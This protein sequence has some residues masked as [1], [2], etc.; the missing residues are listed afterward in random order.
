MSGA[1]LEGAGALS[2]FLS[3]DVDG[4][5]ISSSLFFFF[6]LQD[7]SPTCTDTRFVFTHVNVKHD[8]SENA[9]GGLFPPVLYSFFF[10]FFVL[11]RR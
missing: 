10:F 1:V 5:N 6:S 7:S 8:G 11:L 2:Q 3:L 9:G 4:Q